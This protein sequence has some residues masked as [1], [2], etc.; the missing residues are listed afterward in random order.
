MRSSYPRHA[1]NGH[2]AE[3]LVVALLI[4]AALLLTESCHRGAKQPAETAPQEIVLGPADTTV[5][6]PGTIQTGPVLSG[7]LTALRQATV[8]AQLAGSV[9]E[10]Y[11]EPGQTVR[12]GQTLARLDTSALS[13]AATSARAGVATAQSS[14]ALAERE[15]ERQRILAQVGAVADREAETAR[16]Q[17]A[18]ARAQ[19]A[20]ARAQLAAAQKQLGNT[21]IVAPFDGVVSERPVSAGDVVQAG[22]AVYTVVDPDSLQLEAAVPTERLT[23]LTIGAPVQLQVNGFP[24][25][26]FEGR[27][28]RINPSADPATRQVRVYAEIPNTGNQLVAGLFAQGRVATEARTGLTLPE[29]AIDRRLQKPA[30]LRVREGKVERV[31]VQLGLTDEEKQRVEVVQGLQAGDVVLLGAAQQ[32]APGTPVKLAPQVQQKVERLA[33]N[34]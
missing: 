29:E 21:R 2:P 1:R 9:L 32:I 3:T 16:Q 31:D 15:A 12:A 19:L 14:L 34:L 7:T 5:V 30:V 10:I 20:Q 11:A 22:S 25:R 24:G 26:T 18:V 13:D 17:T 33:Q 27:I 23:D 4:A 8:R 6:T 28:A